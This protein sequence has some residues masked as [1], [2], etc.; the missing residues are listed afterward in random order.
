MA[1]SLHNFDLNISIISL[2]EQMVFVKY[3]FNVPNMSFFCVCDMVEVDFLH[4][5]LMGAGS[6]VLLLGLQRI[7]T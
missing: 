2:S 4:I 7:R 6:N 3:T 1:I 5:G